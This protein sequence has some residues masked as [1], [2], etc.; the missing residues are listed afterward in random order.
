MRC[1]RISSIFI[2]VCFIMFFF[3]QRNAKAI[4]YDRVCS[5]I[6]EAEK[7][8]YRKCGDNYIYLMDDKVNSSHFVSTLEMFTDN[9]IL[10]A[11]KVD[12]IDTFYSTGFYYF[13]VI[14]DNRKSGE[15]NYNYWSDIVL[16]GSVI[17]DG[18]FEDT[19]LI[20]QSKIEPVVFYNAAG[21]YL[22][23]QYKGYKITDIIKVIIP[24]KKDYGIS[25]EEVKY[26]SDNISSKTLTGKNENLEFKITGGKY[27]FND[28]VNVNVNGC[29]FI[30]TFNKNLVID[31]SK[32]K[33]CLKY[34]S[35][36]S[37]SL[38]VYNGFNLKKIFK[39]S[40][41]LNSNE[42]SIKLEDS[43][44]AIETSSRRVL[45]KSYA[46]TGKS[47]QD[48]FNLYYWSKSPDDDLTYEDFI[49]NYENSMYRGSYSSSRGVILRGAV[50]T[51]YLYA[52][53]K[54]EDSVIVVRSNAYI[55]KKKAKLN[56]IITKDIIFVGALVV[57]GI[58][59]IAIYL[60]IRG[61][62]ND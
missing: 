34:N 2:I 23:R 42:V 21:T 41:Y 19:W 53:A 12:G 11:G 1:I 3:D 28:D 48:E 8:L 38:S 55:L 24:K 9:Q 50:G 10:Y 18:E 16:N 5:E 37:V 15:T 36:N 60:S 27:G 47:L 30:V 33:N 44:S 7:S 49:N 45:I 6:I 32:F 46:G 39:Y 4:N 56:K 13:S 29:E 57:L 31:N 61:K 20:D 54:D 51:Y 40:F 58:V 62:D 25:V 59:P 26:G 52:M 17:Y 22:I 43:V 35:S 14:Y